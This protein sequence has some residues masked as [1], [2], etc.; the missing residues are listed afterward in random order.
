MALDFPNAPTIGQK[1][2]SPATAGVPVYTWDGAKWTTVGGAVGGKTPVYT[3]GSQAMAAALTLFGLPLNPTDAADK[4]Y[5][6]GVAGALAPPAGSVRYDTAQTL[7]GAQQTQAQS[8][9]GVP[10]PAPLPRSYLAGLTLSTPGSSGSFAVAAGM[11]V[12]STNAVMMAL[13]SAITKTTSAYGNG[14]GALDSGAIAASTWYHA[15]LIKNPTTQTVDALVS[16]SATAP[17]LPSGYTAFRRIG[18]MKTNASSQWILFHQDG[19][20]FAWD[21]PVVDATGSNPGPAAVTRALVGVPVGI[22][23]QAYIQL[24]MQTNAAVADST[25]VSDLACADVAPGQNIATT[26]FTYSSAGAG[27]SSTMAFVFT[28]T[29][30]QVRTRMQTGSSAGFFINT[31]GW[32]DR[33]GRDA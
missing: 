13:A 12:D 4:A 32:I 24:A 33:R 15:H 19:D 28:N 11:A 20:V 26:A 8:N 25:L 6:D 23:I 14:N 5:V 27:G 7:T 29:L 3:D 21:T 17:T 10:A 2:P 18:A 1:F 9:I 16:L 31:F 22:R 30:A